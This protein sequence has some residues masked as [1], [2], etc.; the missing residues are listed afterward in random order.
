MFVIA[1]ENGAKGVKSGQ[2]SRQESVHHAYGFPENFSHR[3]NILDNASTE[4]Q[5]YCSDKFFSGVFLAL[6]NLSKVSRARAETPVAAKT[7]QCKK[8]K[9][10][11][12]TNSYVCGRFWLLFE[13]RAVRSIL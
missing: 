2:E 13:V 7:G 12:K 6:A 1:Q 10:E 3:F 11:T 9:G 5:L 4:D 8:K